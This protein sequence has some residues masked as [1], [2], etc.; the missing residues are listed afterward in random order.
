METK[1]YGSV[2]TAQIEVADTSELLMTKQLTFKIQARGL[3]NLSNIVYNVI[4][5]GFQEIIFEFDEK[6]LIEMLLS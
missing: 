4:D 2:R 6:I 1:I 3:A 5:L